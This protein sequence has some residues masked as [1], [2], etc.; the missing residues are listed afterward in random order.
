MR[1]SGNQSSIVEMFTLLDKDFIHP[2]AC[3]CK[4]GHNGLACHYQNKSFEEAYGCNNFVYD[5][6]YNNGKITKCI[7]L[8]SSYYNILDGMVK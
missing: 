1:I 7:D 3:K 8:G 4:N 6:E 2:F 5:I